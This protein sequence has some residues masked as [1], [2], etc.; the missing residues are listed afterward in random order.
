MKVRQ[1]SINDR[2][3]CS[4]GN[5]V[6]GS[7]ELMGGSPAKVQKSWSFNDRTRFRPSLRL[8]S[9]TRTAAP[10]VDPGMTTDDSFDE[11]GCHCDVTVEDL[12]APL[13]AVIRA[14][15]I[16]KFHVAKKKFKETL[17]PYDVKDVIEQY[18]AGHLDMLYRIKSLQTRLD[19]V[20]GPP[21]RP[22][23]GHIKT[24]SSPS[25]HLYYNQTRRKQSASGL[26]LPFPDLSR[27]GSLLTWPKPE[28]LLT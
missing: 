18:S 4:P 9:Q 28:M 13:K 20:V 16:M 23:R 21:P 26:E 3:R 1:T 25:L 5:E 2:Q 15:R 19:T 8:K 17:R 24:F 22:L 11:K 14:V 10:D 12:S 7:S 6:V 27:N